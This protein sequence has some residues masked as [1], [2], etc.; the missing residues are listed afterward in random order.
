MSNLRT[1]LS[2][3]ATGLGAWFL[4]DTT[5]RALQ[6]QHELARADAKITASQEWESEGGALRQK[7]TTLKSH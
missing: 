4:W 3:I 2:V 1:L 6:K 7:P 5:R